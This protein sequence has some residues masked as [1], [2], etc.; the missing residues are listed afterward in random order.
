MGSQS[1]LPQATK[2]YAIVKNPITVTPLPITKFSSQSLS[3]PSKSNECNLYKL[4]YIYSFTIT[5]WTF[6][7]IREFKVL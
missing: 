6:L 1:D 3:Q 2:S 4:R 5:N 7:T